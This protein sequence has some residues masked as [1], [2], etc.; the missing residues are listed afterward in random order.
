MEREYF[1]KYLL[2][3]SYHAKKKRRENNGKHVILN[4]R[5]KIGVRLAKL[6]SL[7]S[8]SRIQ[9]LFPAPVCSS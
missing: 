7:N 4:K 2:K 5:I 3:Y 6:G 8:R 1:K 9:T